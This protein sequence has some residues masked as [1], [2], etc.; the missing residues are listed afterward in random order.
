MTDQVKTR[1][2]RTRLWIGAAIAGVL[3]AM[4]AGLVWYLRSPQ[5]EDFVRR[6][7][8]AT[9]EDATGGRVEL[10]A[11]HWK[12]SQLAFQADN[13]TIH[14]LE[15][16]EQLP[17]AHVDRALVR[18]HIISFIERQ[19][20]L[21]QVDLQHPV[22]HII[23]HPDGTTNAPEP[24]IKSSKSPVQQLFDLA[25]ARAD[26]RD[27]MLLLN[28]RRIP[29]D[30]SAHD[31]TAAM[32][33][34]H[35]ARRYDGS[36]Q[37]GRMDVKYQDFR[38]VPAQAQAQF[39]LWHDMAEIRNLKL[40]SEGSS[41]Q[42]SGKITDFNHPQVQ[43]TYSSTLSAAQLGSITRVYQLRGGTML[44]D[45]SAAYSETT[46]LAS[47]GRIAVRDFDYLDNGIV[48][49]QA[50]L[51]SNFSFDNNH[52]ALTR[53]A[54]RLLGGQ[55]TG[56]A[57]VKNLV[58]AT[59]A[60]QTTTP[61]DQLAT[62]GKPSSNQ[63][64]GNHRRISQTN[65]PNVPPP[66]EGSAR[67][68]VSGLSLAE[69][70]RMMSTRSLPLDKLNLIGSVAGSV[71]L[72]WKQSL[73]DLF[74]DLAL[75]VSAPPQ[76][77]NNQLPVNGSL[78]GR[79]NARSGV[80]NLA[81]L[82]LTTPHTHLE[83]TGTLGSTSVALQ[84]TVHT[85][86]LSEFQPLLTAIGN[87]PVPVELAGS[88]SFSGT[89]NDR[90]RSPRIA[91]HLQAS[92][93]TYLYMPTSK[94]A[95]P[96]RAEISA[97]RK[98]WFHLSS[99][100]QPPPPPQPAAQPR[101][102]HIDEFS[103][104]VQYS[105]SGVALHHAMIQEAGAQ[106]NVDGTTTLDKGNFT[107]NSQFQIQAAM[108]NADVTALQRA[109]GLDYPVTG[110]L[111]FTLQAAGT[112]ADPH[113]HGRLSLT[114]GQA[115]GRPIKSLS[116]N[117]VFANRAAQLEDIHLQAARGAIE[118]AAAYNFGNH[119]LTFNL[120][121]HSIDLAEIPELQRPHLQIAGNANFTAKGAGTLEQPLINGHLQ[122]GKLVLN[123]EPIGAMEA[124][125]ETHG[126]QLQLTARS[127]FTQASLSLDGNVDLQGN[128]PANL[129]LQFSNLDI[130][131][132]LPAE[133]RS[134]VTRRT[135]LN[136]HAQLSGP[137]KQPQLL[138]GSFSV[139]EVSV[140]IEHIALK[141]DGPVELSFANQVVTVQ[142]C[143]L[144][145][146]DSHF[147]LSGSASLR[148]DRRLDL[149]ANGY[150]NL[151][152]AQTL[153]PELTA[154]GA[155]NVDLTIYG[156]ASNPILSGRVD[157]VHAGLTMI[158]LPVGLG[159]V[160]GTL[161]FNQDRLEI[162][163]LTGRM[164][165]GQVNLAGFVTFG[166]TLGFNLTSNG[167][168]IRFRYA[169]ISVTSDQELRLTGT[170]E[171][172]TLSGNVTVTRF[173][174]IPSSDLQFMLAQASAPT[175]IP[176]PK[177]PLNNLHL[178]VRILSSP[179]LTVQTTLAKL[180]GDVDLRLRGTG[181]RPVLLGRINI[182]EG[183]IKLGGTKYHLERGDITFLDPVRIDP[184]LDV[185]ATT[186]V[187]DYDITIGLHGTLERLNTTYRSDPPLSS[188][189][190]VSLLAFGRTQ[191]E[192]ALA[193]AAAS[194][195]FAE[196]ASGAILSSAINQAASN[197]VSKIFGVSAIRINPSVGGPD[198]DPN[199]RL[200]LEQ[201][202]SNN[203]TLTY[204]TNLARS[205]QEVIQFEYNINSEY[206]VQ[207]I[208]DENGVVSF[209]LLIRKRKR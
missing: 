5:F 184:V 55:I 116:S 49:H 29:L 28:Q 42:A 135:A 183:D 160:N 75:D 126:R 19:I 77:A 101:R 131:P 155:S 186:R 88:A 147:S 54:A 68:R 157:I 188:D 24:K 205:A 162:Q 180:S 87:P 69:L 137:L 33:Y 133:V 56:D 2:S 202:V 25:V 31:I 176:N 74:A 102:I 16:P 169:G 78:R 108:H 167:K 34:N 37:V 32:T 45:G 144:I 158:D 99:A 177:S 57:N 60:P 90:L 51:N 150:L 61:T 153:N 134:R 119:A 23:V 104:D 36:V 73:N 41:L 121:G 174:Q 85:T 6:K 172:S 44:L 89:L 142:R 124:D 38:D 21:E 59:S 149:H 39:S 52:L 14:G 204:I 72:S 4:V 152:L 196:S 94:P 122:I 12:L 120:T 130:N 170:L 22:I 141:S 67:L 109:A 199:A 81:A 103:A 95:A 50:N 110:K 198:N 197:R 181:E 71:N 138:S 159:D 139:R 209:D 98:S 151:K 164:G 148:D 123:G 128:M 96:P 11:F 175:T 9:L 165:G 193:G 114:E 166:R 53:I 140:E 200:T 173:A 125:A 48:L 143:T 7:L 43:L 111:N 194:P 80:I 20:S 107:G 195:G 132:F 127:S 192:S 70:A 10:A 208:R 136:G 106:L 17:Y 15:G 105:P 97:K 190:I 47:R 3:L 58:P 145:S 117:L 8:V 185:E 201:Q 86:S 65:N 82:N 191:Q 93:F 83:A 79:H 63:R 92:D 203:I 35:L 84:L 76:V 178:D 187:R 156:T 146:E 30:F 112:E 62:A 64:S 91:G 100:S 115:Y 206:T 163:R 46:G 168:D 18:L 189:D 207:G 161:V 129:N 13:L 66:Q 113:G 154:Y 118:G 179:E 182:A 1:H 171:N 40:S 26:L 27:G